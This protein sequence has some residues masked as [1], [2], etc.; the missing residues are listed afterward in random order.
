MYFQLQLCCYRVL[1]NGALDAFFTSC[2]Y[3]FHQIFSDV[4]LGFASFALILFQEKLTTAAYYVPTTSITDVFEMFGSFL[5][6]ELW[7]AL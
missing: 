5:L 4:S 1:L 3:V 6:N 7:A 2:S